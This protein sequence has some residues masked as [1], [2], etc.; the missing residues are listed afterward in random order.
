MQTKE[1]ALEKLSRSSF[2]ARFH[3]TRRDRDYIAAKG[4]ETIEDHARD[5]VRQRLAPAVID[6]DGRQTPMRGHPVFLAQH[7]CACC[8]RGCLEKWYRVPRGQALSQRQQE[9]IVGLL[10]AWI[11][12]ELESGPEAQT[13]SQ[14]P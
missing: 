8:C 7:A 11:R 3:L 2:R 4:L 5:F 9:K 10:M 12:R 1:E 14:S 13:R 6:N